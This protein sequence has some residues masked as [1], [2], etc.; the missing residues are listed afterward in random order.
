MAQTGP[1]VGQATWQGQEGRA[2]SL[3]LPLAL[4]LALLGS[5]GLLDGARWPALLRMLGRVRH[6]QVCPQPDC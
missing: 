3:S 5:S 6:I 1:E 2:V 4:A